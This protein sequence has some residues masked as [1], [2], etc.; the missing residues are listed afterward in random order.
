MAVV[1]NVTAGGSCASIA[2]LAR[3]PALIGEH[4]EPVTERVNSNQNRRRAVNAAERRRSK[5]SLAD[6]AKELG[7]TFRTIERDAKCAGRVERQMAR[8]V[9][10]AVASVLH[11]RPKRLT[12]SAVPVAVVTNPTAIVV[13]EAENLSQLARS[14]KVRAGFVDEF[15]WL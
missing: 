5:V 7:N 1:S 9:A 15:P 12:A 10:G 11:D 13:M 8:F 14:V 3:E 6:H 4:A 2:R